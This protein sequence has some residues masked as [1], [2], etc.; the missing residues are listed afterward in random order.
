MIHIAGA[1]TYSL[2]L[3]LGSSEKTHTGTQTQGDFSQA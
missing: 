2:E 1:A 3:S